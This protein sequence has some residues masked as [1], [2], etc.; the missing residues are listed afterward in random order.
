MTALLYAGGGCLVASC[1]LWGWSL[2]RRDASVVDIWW[3][4]GFVGVTWYYYQRSGIGASWQLLH[5]LLVSLWGVRLAMHI[6][7]RGRGEGEDR[8]YAAMRK[9]G[10]KEFWRKSLITVFWLQAGLVVV[11][12]FPLYVVQTT[13]SWSYPSLFYLGCLLWIVGFL[14]EA[15]ADW[16]LLRFKSVPAN[17]GQV[18][19]RGLWRYSRHPNYF[20]ESLL[21]WGYGSMALAAGSFWSLLSPL[22]MTLLL[23]RVSGVTLLEKTITSRRPDYRAYQERTSAFV[24]WPPRSASER[25]S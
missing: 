7:W 1:L 6:A 3:G 10:G 12:S 17:A 11:L 8:R 19:D 15:V 5:L 9:R 16:Q 2:W 22:M 14:F 4:L 23:L 25:S 21:W 18:L 13:A 20:G 24:P